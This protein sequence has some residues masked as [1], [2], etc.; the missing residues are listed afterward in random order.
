MFAL[1]KDP[2][3]SRDVKALT[4]ANWNLNIFDAAK[5]RIAPRLHLHYG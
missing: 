1:E 4:I 5:S 3:P 2:Y